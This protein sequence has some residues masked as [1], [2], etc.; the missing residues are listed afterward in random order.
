MKGEWRIKK[1][2]KIVI[3]F[4]LVGLMVILSAC[5][6][7]SESIFLTEEEQAWLEQ[8]EGKISIG[9]T[10]DYPPV[11]FLIASDYVGIS[12]D[13]FKL[14][15][16]KLNTKFEMVEFDQWS[17]LIEAARLKEVSGITA[18]TKTL[19][20]SKF[21][22]FTVP[23]IMNPNVI[24][25]RKNFSEKLTFE[26]LSNSSMDVLVIEEYSIVEDLEKNHP[27]LEFR[28]VANT[29][30]GLRLVAFGEADAFI[31][32]VMSAYAG[33]EQDKMT[34][35]MV[36][37]EVPYDS[38][39]S[40]ATRN[41]WPM[42]SAILNKGLAQITENE[43][44]DILNKWVPIQRKSIVENPYF[45]II[46]GTIL[47]GL[48]IIIITVVVWNRLLKKAV[49]EKTEELISKNEQLYRTK[50]QLLEE[51][52]ERKKSEACI[53]FKSQ[54]DELTGLYN[55]AFYNEQ[56]EHFEKTKKLPFSI[57]LA[58]LNGLKI[59]NDTLGHEMGDRLLIKMA[60]VLKASCDET[61]IVARIGGDEFVILMPDRTDQMAQA[62]CKKI[63]SACEE[64]KMDPIKLSVA[65]GH[66]ERVSLDMSL[67]SVFKKA[68]D[69]MYENK[70]NES[71]STYRGILE[72][73]KAKLKATT[74]E[75]SE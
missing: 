45:W 3:L 50:K 9:Y 11:E 2:R 41:D 63:K 22:D 35:L 36:N 26:K 62:V 30:D 28:T 39:L 27:K 59:T 72:S 60:E 67:Q 64:A 20:R 38:N 46:L 74:E 6:K 73:L 43:K 4:L 29:S 65:L 31:V 40:I 32:E 75:T 58:D 66:S 48:S 23:Y 34:N 55:R 47:I 57:I 25:T 53:K 1:Q 24:I 71:E 17:D 51:I 49:L 54:H 8:H 44:Q 70:M 42:L 10:T 61:D 7:E 13:Y 56:L 68:E 37:T 12:A 5:Q 21:L 14:L 16:V 52:E 19:E 15:E 33:I 69:Q 18:A